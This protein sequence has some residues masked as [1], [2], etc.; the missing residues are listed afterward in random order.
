M[1]EPMALTVIL[2]LVVAFVLSLTFVPALIAIC[3]H[4]PGRRRRRTPLVRV[5]QG[6]STSRCSTRAMRA[7][8]PVDRRRGRCC[9]SLAGF[10]VHAARTGVHPDARRE[11]HRACTRCASPSTRSDAVAGDAARGR[12]GDQRIARG[13]ASSSR[14][15]GTAEIASDPMPPN[16]SDTFVILKPQDAVARPEP[17]Q[18]RAASS[19]SRTRSSEL[20]GNTY[21][22]TQPIQMRFNELIAGVRGDVAVKVFG[23]DFEPMLRRRQ[24]DRRRSCA[25]PRARPT[26]RSSRPTACRCSRSTIDKAEIARRGLS[27]AAVQDVIGAAIGGREAGVVFEGDRRFADR[28]PPAGSIRDDLDALKNLPVPLPPTGNGAPTVP[29]RPGRG[30]R[31]QRRPEPDQPRE[32]QAPRR[33]HANV[34][35]RDIGSVVAE[36][37]AKIDAQVKLPAGYWT[38]W[39]GQFENLAAARAAP[40]D[41]RA[42]LLRR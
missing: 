31:R 22:F 16:A 17:D 20:P 39:G 15:T 1:F 12:E 36:A 18:G 9:S 23:D 7:P 24:P 13:R 42:G 8:V 27:L 6:A 37:Q 34:R 28:R 35:G 11:E 14:K 25:R 40:G 32:R 41:R 33:G 10:A 4:R 26:S 21:E 3:H 2:A 30:V 5:A 19:R 38:E 29:L